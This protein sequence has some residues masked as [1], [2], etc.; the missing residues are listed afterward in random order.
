[1]IRGSARRLR[2][3][4]AEAKLTKIKLGTRTYRR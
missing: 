2:I 3:D 4:P 1:M